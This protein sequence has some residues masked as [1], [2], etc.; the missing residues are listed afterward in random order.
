MNTFLIYLNF[1]AA[2]KENKT[3][4]PI[5]KIKLPKVVVPLIEFTKCNLNKLK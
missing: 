5:E 3:Y 4:I 1:V 2:V